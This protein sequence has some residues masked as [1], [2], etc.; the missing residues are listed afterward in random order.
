MSDADAG[1]PPGRWRT[2]VRVAGLACVV[3]ALVVIRVLAYQ[4]RL[5][6]GPGF[7]VY[8]SLAPVAYLVPGLVLLLRRRWHVVGWLLCLLAL[9]FGFSFSSEVGVSAIRAGEAWLVWVLDLF[10]G[11]LLWL[12]VTA[13]FVVFPDGLG[14]QTAHQRRVGRAVVVLAAVAALPDPFVTTVGV[15]DAGAAV[16]PSPLPFAFVPRPVPD[17]TQILSW[18]ALL[19][20]LVGLMLRY[21][22]SHAAV[23]RQYRWVL[24]SLAFMI[25]ALFIG[26][27]GATVLQD[28]NGTAW[29]PVLVAYLAI[30]I[31]FMVAILRYR[32]YE[33]DRL[34]SR[35]VTYSVVVAVLAGVYAVAATLATVVLPSDS[36]VAVAASTLAVA[37]AFRPLQR[38]VRRGV[39]HRFNR[40]RFDADIELERF[41]R[42]LRDQ[43]D[44]EL[45]TA[46]L[47]AVVGHTMQPTTLR[48]WIARGD[49][50]P[51]HPVRAADGG[52]PD[53][54]SA[55]RSPG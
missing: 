5:T 36:N 43:T 20:A 14:A 46:Q 19:A 9:A 41:A 27:V 32:L 11:S 29:Y 3:G 28:P 34:V 47:R 49:V 33:I 55:P 6:P 24:W 21:R 31:A 10:E 4:R 18:A 22:A 12:L 16:L 30:P 51:E 35:T 40:S 7:L 23:R 2:A 17:M 1:T 52:A 44:L 45:V 39:D 25:L 50:T 53:D 54:G 8:A 42:S 48:L 15:S 38:R 37:A 13:L 26:L